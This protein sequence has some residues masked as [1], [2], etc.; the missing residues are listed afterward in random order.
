MSERSALDAVA[1][2]FSAAWQRGEGPSDACLALRGRRIAVE[3][4]AVTARSGIAE[5]RLRYDRVALRFVRDL[6]EMLRPSLASGETAIVAIRA[7]ILQAS[8]TAAALYEK[9]RSH[10]ESKSKKAELITRAHGNQITVRLLKHGSGRGSEVIA[11]VHSAGSSAATILNAAQS[12]LDRL[13]AKLRNARKIG[14]DRWLVLIGDAAFAETYR[15]VCAQLA[16][17]AGFA[18]ILLVTDD[19][20]VEVLAG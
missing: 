13:Y 2:H 5:P 19:D 14:G 7:P 17:P 10:R 16:N 12:L 9:I 6:R 15:E 1:K 4:P 11:F 8:K 20:R 18:K 3:V